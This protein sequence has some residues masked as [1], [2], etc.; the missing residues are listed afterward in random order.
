[1]NA[2]VTTGTGVNCTMSRDDLLAEEAKPVVEDID[3]ML[4]ALYRRHLCT[5]SW[6][7]T[8]PRWGRAGSLLQELQR[9]RESRRGVGMEQRLDYES[10]PDAADD[11]RI[12]W[13]L[14][15]EIFWVMRNSASYLREG[16]RLLDAGGTASVFACYLASL[17]F[18]VHAVDLNQRLL[19]H[20]QRVADLMGWNMKSY[21]LNLAD[22]PFEPEFF[23]HAY[24]ICVFE[25]LDYDVKQAALGEIWRCLRR[26]GTLS[27]TFDYRNPAPGVFGYGKDPRSRNQIKVP[28]DIERNFLADGRFELVG[29]PDFH[30]NGKSYLVHRRFDNTPYTFGAVF[31]RKKS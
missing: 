8:L 19:E 25:H 23:D 1:M 10:L 14:Y 28:E 15:W 16:M 12:P 29:N 6:L 11:G 13:F 27:L 4:R 2:S 31:L 3:A 7:G 9:R 24:S 20:G 5:T 30:D 22:L 18:E 21:A 17:G 26:G